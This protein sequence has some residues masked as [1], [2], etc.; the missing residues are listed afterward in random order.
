MAENFVLVHGAWHGAWCWAGVI[1]ALERE[2]HRAYAV[3]LP[4]R[5]GNDR[6]ETAAKH[7]AASHGAGRNRLLQPALSARDSSPAR[8]V[9]LVIAVGAVA[10]G[11][12]RPL[13]H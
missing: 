3:D 7:P 6:G 5:P 8:G 11:L 1:A 4:G 9:P 10:I 2:G 13:T 12:F